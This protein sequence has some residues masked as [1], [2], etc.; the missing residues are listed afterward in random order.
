[1]FNLD[2]TAATTDIYGFERD[3]IT[4]GVLYSL[5]VFPFLDLIRAQISEVDLV[6][7][8]P[9]FYLI[10]LFISFLFL[11]YFSDLFSQV[12][13]QLDN[14]KDIGI[15]S[16][17]KIKLTNQ[18][19]LSLTF[20]F[21]GINF[22]FCFIIPISLDSFNSYGE[23]TIENLWSFN[24]VI[25]LEVSLLIVLIIAAQLPLILLNISNTES[26]ITNVPKYWKYFVFGFVVAA[27]FLTPTIDG[28]TQLSFAICACIF[29]LFVVFILFKRL[30]IKI[31]KNSFL[32]F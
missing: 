19:R 12:Q 15:K 8:V 21:T 17:K 18:M 5:A 14:K 31:I 6:Q 7:V 16:G 29:Y 28:S 26:S 2:E 9:G 22:S 20:F 27:G 1:M 30:V 4:R 25:G 13:F 11:V 3:L 23:K 24:Q 10:L 32:G